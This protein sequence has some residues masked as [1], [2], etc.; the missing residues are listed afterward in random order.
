MRKEANMFL[1]GGTWTLRIA[2]PKDILAIRKELG[3]RSTREVWKSLGTGDAKAAQLRLAHARAEAL[4]GF[5][6]ERQAF[7][8]R[9]IPTPDQLRHAGAL[10]RDTVKASL[11]N[12]RLQEL[13]SPSDVARAGAEL[14]AAVA[15]GYD[16]DETLRAS[17][18]YHLEWLVGSAAE[19]DEDRAELRTRL[20]AELKATD[21]KSVDGFIGHIA[22]VNG[23]KIVEDG[24]EYR[25]LARLL[26]TAWIEA[27]DEAE[28]A[29]TDTTY[30]PL[31]QAEV[32]GRW[33]SPL[34]QTVSVLVEGGEAPARKEYE[35]AFPVQS[36]APRVKQDVRHLHEVYLSE[37]FPRLSE[38]GRLERVRNVTQFVEVCGLKEPTEY[39][40]KD[41]AAFK[42][43]LTKLP[44]NA[45][46]DF[47]GQT[48]SQILSKAKPTSASLADKTV[49]LRLSH[50][51]AFGKWMANNVDGVD[52]ASFA[53]SAPSAKNKPTTVREFS[54][55]QIVKIF[56]SPTFVGCQSERNQLL[57]GSYKVRD[58][59]FWL[60]LLAAFTGCRLN[61]LT[62]LRVDDIQQIGDNWVFN[63]T[64]SSDGQSL[65]TKA[66]ERIVPIH[67]EIL[68]AGFIARVQKLRAQGHDALFPDIPLDRNGRRSETAGK[69]FRKFIA[70]LGI[71][72]DAR[73]GFHRF[74]HG[75][76]E[77][78]RLAGHSDYEIA[79]IV[80]HDT[81]IASMTAKYGSSRQQL[82]ERRKAVLGSLEYKGLAGSN[83]ALG[84]S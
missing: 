13:A 55:E 4:Q 59:R 46:R 20:W 48:V 77:R 43:A 41:M 42:Q 47:P 51:S 8:A 62:Q 79:L 17:R 36:D 25:H 84:G 15:S 58:Y 76:V 9:P 68:A 61:E 65:K 23:F 2:V 14:T 78:L 34:K 1:R 38:S 64:A 39:R 72:D 26:Q 40:K 45:A 73:G 50:M 63:I 24:P 71:K 21:P 80:G 57:P 3:K 12:E 10:F 27:L 35:D 81:G 32:L 53:T 49:R 82:V 30:V 19:M 29:I 5:E 54:D 44:P 67:S 69:R 56:H 16:A 83:F 70:R 52:A 7:G 6:D 37:R 33:D 11:L 22:K 75:V 66:S 74:R 18:L 60:P 28:S 31:T